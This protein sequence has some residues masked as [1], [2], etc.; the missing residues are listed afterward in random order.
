MHAFE[1]IIRSDRWFTIPGV[2]VIIWL[3]SPSNYWALPHSGYWLDI[4]VN[5]AFRNLWSGLFL[6]SCSFASSPRQPGSRRNGDRT[7]GLAS[8]PY[9]IPLL[10]IV[11]ISSIT[12][13][14]CGCCFDGTQA[15]SARAINKTI[16][17]NKRIVKLSQQCSLPAET[18]YT[19]YRIYP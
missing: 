17:N 8:L 18:R 2:V 7:D 15:Q 13:A 9:L 10:G 1:G 6:Q 3:D 19:F 16:L 11:G 14:S 4:L 5:C 12:H